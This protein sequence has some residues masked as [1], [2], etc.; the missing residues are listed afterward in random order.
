MFS[1][2]VVHNNCKNQLR[3]T[4][5]INLKSNKFDTH[6]KITKSTPIC[7]NYTFKQKTTSKNQ[8]IHTKKTSHQYNKFKK[9]IILESNRKI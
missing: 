1:K 5:C 8:L 2:K 9:K 6:S 7:N 3:S 4:K